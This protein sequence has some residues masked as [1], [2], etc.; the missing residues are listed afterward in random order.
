MEN[1]KLDG[2]KMIAAALTGHDHKVV[3]VGGEA[4]VI[5]PPTIHRLAG[6]M[7]W[8]SDIDN[9]PTLKDILLK[10]GKLDNLCR[11]LS[12]FIEDNDSLWE[13]L[14][15]G[16]LE[17]IVAALEVAFSLIDVTNFIK[18]STLLRSARK[19]IAKQNT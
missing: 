4:F 2:A 10:F 15:H 16:T 1:E 3:I 14:S 7:Y 8:M 9:A 5:P 12:C 18:L 6:A 17:E 11:A 19:L 13:K